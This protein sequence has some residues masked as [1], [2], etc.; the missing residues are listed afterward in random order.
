MMKKK[1][2]VIVDNYEYREGLK[3]DWGFSAL[4]EI[5]YFKILFDLGNEPEIFAHNVEK[6]GIDLSK[7]DCLFVSHYDSDHIGG[8]EV[9]LE[10]NKKAPILFPDNPQYYSLNEKLSKDRKVITYRNPGW[11][12]KE[13]LGVYTTGNV[14][15]SPRPEHSLYFKGESGWVIIG[16]CSHPGVWNIASRVR[17]LT[18]GGVELYVGGYHFYRMNEKEVKRA[19]RKVIRAG[20]NRVGP[21]HCTGDRAREIFKFI[22]DEDFVEVGVGRVLEWS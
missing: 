11:I 5:G 16:G 10:R 2:T 3:T 21:C 1:L 4:L 17:E 20:V 14:E 13:D 6:L 12:C 15:P 8:L 22:Y 9:F 18:G 19:V 7:I